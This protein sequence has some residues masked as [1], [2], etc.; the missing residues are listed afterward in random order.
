MDS[1]I[2]ILDGKTGTPLARTSAGTRIYSAANTRRLLL[3]AKK[4]TDREKT[5]ILGK[6]M[7]NMT[8]AHDQKPVQYTD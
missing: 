3:L 1:S 2:I 6:A 7:M 4:A 8:M 5:I